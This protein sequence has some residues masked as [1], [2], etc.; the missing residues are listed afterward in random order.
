LIH[1]LTNLHNLRYNLSSGG[2][3]QKPPQSSPWSYT[4]GFSVIPSISN[5]WGNITS[6]D[7]NAFGSLNA[8]S[9]ISQMMKGLIPGRKYFISWIQ[10]LS[11]IE[12][13]SFGLNVSVGSDILYSEPQLSNTMMWNFKTSTIFT[14]SSKNMALNFSSSVGPS[15]CIAL[16]HIE[17]NIFYNIMGTLSN[18]FR[19]H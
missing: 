7:G 2:A 19:V 17:V 16:D 5:S 12:P 1:D 4:G 14:A 6:F 13:T 9:S 11:P 10:M 18:P 15:C 3:L 8:S